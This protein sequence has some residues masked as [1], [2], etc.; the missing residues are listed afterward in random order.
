MTYS[1]ASALLFSNLL[2]LLV[3]DLGCCFLGDGTDVPDAS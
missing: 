1:G 3:G 2:S